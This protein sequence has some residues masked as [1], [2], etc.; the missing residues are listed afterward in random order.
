MIRC[1]NCGASNPDAARFCAECGGALVPA[2]P[3]KSIEKPRGPA[4]IDATGFAKALSTRAATL[5]GKKKT[6]VVFVLDCTGS[7]Q[8]EIDAIK[9]AITAFADTIESEGVRV[10][11]GLVEFRDR[12]IHEE[13]R[14]LTFSGQPFTSDPAA[15]RREVSALRATGGGDAP[16]SSLDAVMLALRQP[17]DPD[18]NKVIVLVTDAPPH[19]PDQE[20]RSIDEVV[21][22]IRSVRVEQFYLVIRTEDQASQV[23]LKLL[24]SSRGMAFELGKGDD[25]RKRAEDFKRTLMALGKTI[26]S[27]T[28]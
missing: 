6:D 5:Q 11:V 19:L 24:E 18:A 4:T 23:Y 25:F 12:L 26:S 22:A 10:R 13:A 9:D 20:T 15:F 8:G 14:V 1:A 17:Y 21:Q 16:E 7:M 27:A 3:V 2:E 28:R